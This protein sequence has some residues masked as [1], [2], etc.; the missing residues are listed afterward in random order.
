M[1]AKIV[2]TVIYLVEKYT[3]LQDEKGVDLYYTAA[4]RLTRA[5]AE[6]DFATEIAQGSVR[7]R[8][9]KATK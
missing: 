5:K 2:Q 1:K 4:A 9:M 6:E 7:V 3:G 8:K